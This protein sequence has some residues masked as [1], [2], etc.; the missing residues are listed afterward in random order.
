[1]GGPVTPTVPTP[2]PTAAS[3]AVIDTVSVVVDTV[4]AV[5]DSV[6]AVVDSAAS[7]VDTEASVEGEVAPAGED[8]PFRLYSM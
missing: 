1:M 6:A 5:V 3:A 4:A 8:P 7:V 2:N